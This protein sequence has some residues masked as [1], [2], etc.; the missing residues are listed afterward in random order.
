[1]SKCLALD[2]INKGYVRVLALFVLGTDQR[3][4]KRAEAEFNHHSPFIGTKSLPR[5]LLLLFFKREKLRLRN[6]DH[7]GWSSR[8]AKL[9]TGKSLQNTCRKFNLQPGEE[10]LSSN[11][12]RY[13][14]TPH[15][16]SLIQGEVF[17]VVSR[18]SYASTT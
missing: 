14:V 4:E 18:S 8:G 16:A 7:D 3:I 12:Y 10:K 6:R 11:P 13:V 17:Q 5:S 15:M 2:Q 1:M 9:H